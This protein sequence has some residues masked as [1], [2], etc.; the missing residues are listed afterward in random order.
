MPDI[1]ITNAKAVKTGS[2]RQQAGAAASVFILAEDLTTAQSTA[3]NAGLHD[4]VIGPVAPNM[5][6][7]ADGNARLLGHPKFKTIGKFTG[8]GL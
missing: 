6:K 5:L 7:S 1:Y 4:K 8:A 3:R 2:R